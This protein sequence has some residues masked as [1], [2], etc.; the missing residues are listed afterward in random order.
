MTS[1]DIQIKRVYEAPAKSDG[2]RVLVDRLWPRGVKKEDLPYDLWLKDIT[3]S[4]ELRK[5]FHA[6]P[7]HWQGF[8]TRYRLELDERIESVALLRE[9][10][11][12]T[13]VTLLFA[14]KNPEH[15]H[16]IILRDYLLGKD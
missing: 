13:R 16:A 12:Q 9:K 14:S 8:K 3:P 11:A 15:N 5:W 7:D 2:F 4:T 10:A 1:L 6:D